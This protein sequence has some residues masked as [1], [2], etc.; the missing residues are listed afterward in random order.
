MPYTP[1]E[2]RELPFYQNLIDRD[3]HYYLLRKQALLE[4][5][6]ISDASGGNSL[7]MRHKTEG[8]ILLFENPRTDALPEDP[9]TMIIHNTRV[10]KLKIEESYGVLNEVLDREFKEIT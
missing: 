7:L 8:S 5:F 2:L 3:E 1:E 10:K 4:K 9:E 6:S